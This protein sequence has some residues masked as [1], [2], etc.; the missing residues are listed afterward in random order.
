MAGLAAAW[1]LSR[2]RIACEVL[3]K[4]RGL[5]GRA[6]TRSHGDCRF[7]HG[8][9][10]FK[11]EDERVTG[12]VRS[13]LSTED[14]VTIPGDV[15]V[16]DGAGRIHPGD[17][18]INASTKWTYRH[19]ISTLGKLLAA[20]AA[21]ARII[22]ETRIAGIEGEPGRW[23][24]V[25]DR[26]QRF[27]PY[28][29]LL[30]TFPAPQ[31][32]ELLASCS[33]THRLADRLADCTYHRQFT[34]VL[35]YHRRVMPERSFHALINSDRKHALAW[36]SFEDDKPGHVPDGQSIIVAQM[37]P[38]WSAS[39]YEAPREK[40]VGEVVD[41]VATL[42]GGSLPSPDWWDSQRWGFAHP[43]ASLEPELLEEASSMGIHL[44][45]DALIGKGRVALALKTGLEAADRIA[46]NGH[47]GS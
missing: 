43:T 35:G 27:G 45:G 42:L 13:E 26:E 24:M 30:V 1:E 10:Y 20:D 3:E 32:A 4:S 2:R 44:A 34:F 31:A 17:P 37:S 12:L 19:G 29:R 11:L 41:H 5:S 25:D 36:L 21:R 6:A 33:A 16:F 9:N 40:L 15:M 18:S 46:A 47:S 39:H 28:K 14:L 23:T 22:R 8:A 7:D 38:D